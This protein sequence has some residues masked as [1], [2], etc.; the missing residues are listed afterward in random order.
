MSK[1]M[2]VEDDLFMAD[3]LEDVL[4]A[5]GYEVCGIAR[6]VDKAIEIARRDQPDLAIL[7]IHL[8]EGSLGTDIPRQLG[9][10]HRMGILYASGHAGQL[11]LTKS[12]GDAF[13]SKPYRSEDIIRALEIVAQIAGN[14]EA[15]G[16]FPRGFT[17]LGDSSDD[18]DG[19]G[20]DAGA[21]GKK[22]QN[23]GRLLR[24]QAAL[25]EFG[26][27]A[28]G[29]LDLGKVLTR[30][31]QV[32]ASGLGVPFA[33]VC[34]FRAEE[35]DLL[36]EAGVG[37]HQGVIGR[38]VSRAD[39]T[40]P[41]GRAFMT[42][43]PVVCGDLAKDTSFILPAFY[44]EHG[45][46]STVDVV[47]K[48]EGRPYGV[49]EV[50]SP[51]QHIYDQHDINFLTGF[52][53]VLAEAVNTANRNAALHRATI[54]MQE[55]V[56]DKDRLLATKTDLLEEKAMLA[57]ELQHRVR[58]NLQLVHGMLSRQL[59]TTTEVAA[60]DG[61]NAIARRVETLAQV[62]ENLLGTGLSRTID[63]GKYL[64]S[65]CASLEDV[66]SGQ[67][68]GVELMCR[69]VPIMLDLDSV[70]ALGL[71]ASELI[72]NSYAHAFPE[73]AGSIDVALS[74]NETGSAATIVFKDSG[75]GF[76]DTVTSK[77]NGLGL[78]RRL[79]EQ[80][81]GTVSFSSEHGAEWNLTFP[82]PPARP[83]VAASVPQPLSHNGAEEPDRPNV[84]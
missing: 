46:I 20:D 10:E 27:F 9:P 53:N 44:A 41:Q 37:W 83:V 59:L 61:I 13:I 71:V 29:E 36:V 28:L 62:Y 19:D 56:A 1:V 49:L 21:T 75:I 11:N 72:A 55:M 66:G 43:E 40:S 64:S 7:D 50:D 34:R 17:V 26:S 14:G 84:L 78:V 12:D 5:D 16:P 32:C 76:V 58:N 57:R 45:I 31:A 42:G 3:M 18:D 6:T 38:V 30:A 48:K 4:V 69:S 68:P 15:P 65:L 25:A 77:R 60:R 63:F 74:V 39:D 81:N 70:T 54:R 35:K 22:S 52:A 23:I 24:Q 80:I 67:R 79:I 82:I 73:G 33:K 8:A 47:I 51:V 2:I